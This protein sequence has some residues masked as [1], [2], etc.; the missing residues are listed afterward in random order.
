MENYT[1]KYFSFVIDLLRQVADDSG[2]AIRQAAEAV[3]NAIAQDGLFLLFGSGHSALLARDAAYR[4]GGLA[5]ALAIEDIAE[6]D[7]ERM[8]GL[9][10]YILARYELRPNSVLAII[11]NS[12]INPVPIEMALLAKEA[13][14]TI[15]AITSL[16]HSKAVP[17]R[18]SSGKKLY[19]LVDI[20]IDTHSVPGDAAIQLPDTALKSGATST[21]VGSAVLQ[22]ITVQA[23]AL[24]VERGHEPPVWVSANLP[25]G[26]THN[27]ELQARYRP[28]LVRYQMAAMSSPTGKTAH[29]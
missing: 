27:A 3:A 14:L 23:A 15:I 26:E 21:V 25:G 12:G 24:L 2:P 22:G 8:E 6:G 13:G 16:T 5:P 4:A 17:S 1:G 18:H 20:V 28:H 19:E 10:K 29:R 7:A 9:A 11:S